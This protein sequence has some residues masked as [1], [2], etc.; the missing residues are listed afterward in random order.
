MRPVV[1]LLV[2]LFPVLVYAEPK[3]KFDNEVHDFG[4]VQQGDFLEY[5]FV[6]TNVGNED[7]SITKLTGS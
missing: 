7:L 3:I 5:A 1:I 6:F 2:F 4:T